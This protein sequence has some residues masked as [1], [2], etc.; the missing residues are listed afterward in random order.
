MG[1]FGKVRRILSL[2][3]GALSL[4]VSGISY[5]SNDLKNS[6]VKISEKLEKKGIVWRVVYV[7]DVIKRW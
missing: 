3:L 6:S 7:L 5:A 4:R 1:E 2:V